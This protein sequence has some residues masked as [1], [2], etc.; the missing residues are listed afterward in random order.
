MLSCF[1]GAAGARD[2][3][4]GVD[5]FVLGGATALDADFAIARWYRATSSAFSLQ[6]TNETPTAVRASFISR[7]EGVPTMLKRGVGT[8]QRRE[9]QKHLSQ[10]AA[11]PGPRGRAVRLG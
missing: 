9:R 2:V 7:M 4:D 5:T 6:S 10:L 3:F 8:C 1:G 11:N